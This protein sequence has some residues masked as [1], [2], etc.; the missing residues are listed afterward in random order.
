L[1]AARLLE[2]Q[3]MH[4]YTKEAEPMHFIE[5]KNGEMRD[6]TLRDARKLNLYPSVTGIL[7]ILAKPGLEAWKQRQ[8]IEASLTLPMLKGESVDEF[9]KRIPQDAFKSA[10]DAKLRGDTIHKCMESLFKGTYEEFPNDI[11]NISRLAQDAILTYTKGSV[12][13]FI[14]E[15][16]VVGDGYGGMIDLNSPEFVIDYKT[17]DIKDKQWDQYV[18]QKNI[19]P[20]IAY[21]DNCQQLA[22]YDMALTQF[23]INRRLINVYIDRQ[24]PGRVIIHEWK[25]EE[26]KTAWEVFEHALRIWQLSKGYV[27][28]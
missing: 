28:E 21:P 13:D 15:E 9:I 20:A 1:V 18:A 7:D 16:T 24:I 8:V 17:K 10:E 25:P 2:E 3:V 12:V 26:V 22:A 14:A 19:Y 4:W 5:G 27:P 11:V 6:T 23:S